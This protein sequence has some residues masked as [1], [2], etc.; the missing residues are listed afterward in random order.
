MSTSVV[1]LVMADDSA[2]VIAPASGQ[3]HYAGFVE[4]NPVHQF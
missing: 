1:A 2:N 4:A 3:M